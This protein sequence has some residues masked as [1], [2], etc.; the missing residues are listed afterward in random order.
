MHIW[1]LDKTHMSFMEGTIHMEYFG[2]T[3]GHLYFTEDLGT[4][5]GT[6]QTKDLF[7]TCISSNFMNRP[8]KKKPISSA[9]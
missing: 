8:T 1:P 5:P 3:E 4:T 2:G 6:D 7:D 9:F